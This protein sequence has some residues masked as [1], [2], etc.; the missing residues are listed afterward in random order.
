M[1]RANTT[2]PP[3][4][5]TLLLLLGTGACADWLAV[6]D[7]DSR[8]LGPVNGQGG[9]H[10]AISNPDTA[11]ANVVNDPIESDQALETQLGTYDRTWNVQEEI[12]FAD[13]ADGTIFLRFAYVGAEPGLNGTATFGLSDLARGSTPGTNFNVYEV[14]FQI[15]GGTL[16]ARDGYGWVDLYAIEQDHWY[17]LWTVVDNTTDQ[18]AVYLLDDGMPQ[19]R[20]VDL[21]DPDNDWFTFRNSWW[22]PQAND[23]TTIVLRRAGLVLDDIWVDSDG[24]N[25]TDPTEP[26]DPQHT[27]E[28][29]TWALLGLGAAAF[30]VRRRQ[31]HALQR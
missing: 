6:D 23:L 27:P 7:F 30:A 26:D 28:P 4:A 21:D 25:L 9:W 17:D 31:Q 8:N 3:L 18:Y 13:Q 15:S 2:R 11:Y 14:M 16:Q 24:A 10:S 22:R 20:L 12:L 1:P 5:I 19:T 29:T